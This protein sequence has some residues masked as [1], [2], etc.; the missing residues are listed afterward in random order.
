MVIPPL[1]RLKRRLH[2]CYYRASGWAVRHRPMRVTFGLVNFRSPV[3]ERIEREILPTIA[4]YPKGEF[5]IICVDNSPERNPDLEALLKQ[6]RFPTHY[7]WNEGRNTKVAAAKNQI[8]TLAAHPIVV[9][10]CAN[11]GRMYDPTWLED[12]I[13]PMSRPRVAM[14]GHVK[15]CYDAPPEAAPP[16]TLFVQGGV[17]AVKVD[18]MRKHPMPDHLPHSYSDVAIGWHLQKAGYQL[19]DIPT[20]LSYWRQPTPARHHCKY[21]HAED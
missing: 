8:Y 13:R 21:V 16:G 4:H 15:V 17:M 20:I 12:L 7:L 11:H 9:Y 14:T 18:A 6:Q 10:L 19:A 2:A 1:P 3:I 5:E